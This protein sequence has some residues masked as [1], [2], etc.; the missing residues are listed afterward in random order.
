M[1]VF[2]KKKLEKPFNLNK[3]GQEKNKKCFLTN[4]KMCKDVVFGL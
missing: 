3:K 2:C 1:H 4:V